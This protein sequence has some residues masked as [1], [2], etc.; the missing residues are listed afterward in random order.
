MWALFIGAPTRGSL[1]VGTG[2]ILLGEAGRIW[3]AR[4]IGRQSRTRADGAGALATGGPY[5]FVRN[6]LYVF[7]CVLHSG[8]AL[9]MMTPA[10]WALP[11]FV[12]GLYALVVRW[13]ETQVLKVH[14]ASYR[15]YTQRVG[16]FVPRG[17]PLQ[18]RDPTVTLGAALRAER[19]TFVVLL[20]VL[21]GVW[22][23][24]YLSL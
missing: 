18:P 16:R 6:P 21:V 11:I 12:A 19:G 13:E 20:V 3:A 23:R 4:H 24:P 2:L 1:V 7:N 14:G 22:G 9:A 17:K 15:E 8:V 5:R 10:A